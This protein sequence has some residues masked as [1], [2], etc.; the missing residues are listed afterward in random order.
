MKHSRAGLLAL[1]V[2]FGFAAY[3]RSWWLVMGG[4][5]VFVVEY[6]A[7]EVDDLKQRLVRIEDKLDVIS[8]AGSERNGTVS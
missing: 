5:F 7:Q 4:L 3:F 2:I 8:K 6:A 1:A